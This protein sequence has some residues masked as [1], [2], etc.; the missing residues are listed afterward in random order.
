MCLVAEGVWGQNGAPKVDRLAEIAAIKSD[1][2][3]RDLIEIT[4]PPLIRRLLPI[5][6]GGISAAFRPSPKLATA[7][8]LHAELRRQREL[9]APYLKDWSPP[10]EDVRIRLPLEAFDWR[11]ETAEDRA[12]FA[13]TL[14]GEGRWQQLKIPHYGAPMG[15]AVTYYRTTFAVTAAMLAKGALFV[16]FQGVDYKSHIFLNG[17][18]L[19]SHEGL[20]AP[21]EFEFTPHARLGQNVLLIKVVNDFIMLGN[22]ATRGFLPGATDSYQGDKAATD[23]GP[24]WNDAAVGWHECPPGMGVYQDVSI[25][26]RRRLHLHDI[27]VRPLAEEGKAEAWIEVFNCDP[28]PEPVGIELSIVGQNFAATVVRGQLHRPSQAAM[29]GVNCYKIPLT[30]PQP[31]RWEL[32]TPWLYQ[33]QVR[34]RDDKGNVLDTARRQFGLRTFRMEY[35]AEPKGRMYLNGAGIKLRGADTQ[36]AFQQCVM[37][38]DWKQLIDDILLA[39][40]T[41]LN[42]IRLTENPVQSEMYDYCDRLGLMLQTDLP[43][44]GVVKRNQFCEMV[45]QAEEMERLVRAHPSNIL[46]TYINEPSANG[47]GNPQRNLTREEMTRLFEAADAVVHM[48]HPDQVAKAVD[49]DYD[50]PGP[51]LPDNHCYCG[52]YNGHGLDIGK[53]HKGYWQ[54]VKPG[55]RYGCGE[56]GVEGL[57]RVELMRRWYPKPWLPQTA[58]E[59]KQWSPNSIPDEQ[60][61]TLHY[62]FFETPKTLHDWV[63]RSQEYQAWVIR[64]MAEA[65][66]RDRRM[67]SFA[68]HL[69]ID[70]FPSSWMKA[71]IDYER[72]PKPAW[73]AYRE[74]L[75]PLAVNLR[76]DRRA[77]FAGEP[78]ELEAWVCNDRN[79]A[80]SGARLHYQIEHNG[81]VWQAGATAAVVPILDSAYQGTLQFQ[82]LD[83]AARTRM[84]VRLGLLDAGGKVLHDTALSLDVFPRPKADLRRIYVVGSPKGKAAQLAADLGAAPVFA[85]P[86]DAGDAIL[87]DDLSAFGKVETQVAQAVRAGARAV[88]LELPEGKHHIAQTEVAVGGTPTELHFV[89]RATGHRLVE[90]FQ[91]DDFKF[92]YDARLDRPS[93]LLTKPAFRAAGWE[94]ILLSYNAMA[95]GWKADGKGHWCICQI[96]LAHRIAGNPVAAIFARRLLGWSADSAIR[97]PGQSGS[98]K[99]ASLF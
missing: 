36:G 55:W 77:F 18:F 68:A 29:A 96:E 71:I 49:G 13:A 45:R 8:Q 30:I 16:H 75:T 87:I 54:H 64:L 93:P 39:K 84:T 15:R 25:E 56:F 80:P 73:F 42:F 11:I 78:I 12:N 46:V 50:P 51:G 47:L 69:F 10:L 5:D 14:A 91:P 98:E 81:K 21:F 44:F 67:Q 94:A 33:L 38:K 83:V 41:G 60:T 3:N 85:G 70:V 6:A 66:R 82:P 34:L 58:D 99:R 40:I 31:R 43:L 7:E 76:T 88:F 26:A 79:R 53:L 1:F 57:D 32:D 86:I 24:G 62:A 35:L 92:W 4:P 59:E 89:S 72:H 20:F 37:R 17:A 63:E 48:A 52:W 61:G 74:A 97:K 65:F 9:F 23:V 27:F 22:S 2:T 19:G 28:K 95:A 90:G